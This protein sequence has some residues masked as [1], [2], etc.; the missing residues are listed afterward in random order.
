M[1]SATVLLQ[2]LN[3][4]VGITKDRRC[5]C[6]STRTPCC[7]GLPADLRAKLLAQ[8]KAEGYYNRRFTGK[9][10]P[11]AS[12][13]PPGTPA[14]TAPTQPALLVEGEDRAEV[15]SENS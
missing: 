14:P 10:V 8:R 11:R 15:T 4:G 7:E 12:R 6:L 1:Y 5:R 2:L 3:V 9:T 13:P